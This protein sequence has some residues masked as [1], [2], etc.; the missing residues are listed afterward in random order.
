MTAM[1][2]TTEPL[3]TLRLQRDGERSV[4]IHNGPLGDRAVAPAAE[5]GTFEGERLRGE[6]V[7]GTSGDWAIIRPDGS[8]LI[9]ARL[10]LV[11]DD[12]VP[13]FMTYRGVGGFDEQGDA[14]MHTAPLFETSDGNYSWLN[15]VQGIARG[16][17]D[18]DTVVYEV[19]IMTR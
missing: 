6:L 15:G 4:R 1:E 14:W 19:R 9:D 3:F 7:A 18:G 12:G 13:I 17:L 2:L 10:T 8:F 11:T 16:H 5:G